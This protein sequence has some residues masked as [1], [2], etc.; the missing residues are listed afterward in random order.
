MEGIS[1]ERRDFLKRAGLAG[2]FAMMPIANEGWGLGRDS[3]SIVEDAV[4]PQQSEEP[5]KNHI[6]FAVC[7][8]S[9]DHIHGM[10]GAIQRGGVNWFQPG[11]ARKT[12]LRRSPRAFLVPRSSRPRTRY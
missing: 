8:M 6:K 10:V 1:K 3:K 12:R 4:I 11:A 7:G 2:S 9:H 5:P